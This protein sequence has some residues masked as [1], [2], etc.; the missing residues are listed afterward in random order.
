MH[1][2]VPATPDAAHQCPEPWS[3]FDAMDGTAAVPLG[4]L[5]HLKIVEIAIG[6][7]PIAD[8]PIAD[9]PNVKWVDRH[10]LSCPSVCRFPLQNDRNDRALAVAGI[11]DTGE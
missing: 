8:A 7:R 3:A 2:C 11:A 5:R 1:V 6:V 4:L 10:N 9:A